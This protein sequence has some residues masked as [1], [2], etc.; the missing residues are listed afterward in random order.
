MQTIVDGKLI[1]YIR[2][3]SGPVVLILHGWADRADNW[4]QF[5]AKMSNDFDVVVPS[6]PGFGGSESPSKA[7]GLEDYAEF[8]KLF[9]S[10]LGIKPEVII[11]HSNG[12]AI[13][14]KGLADGIIDTNRLVLLASAGIRSTDSRRKSILKYVAKTG[15]VITLVL[16]SSVRRKLRGKLYK[17]IGSDMLVSEH[18]QPTF[19][20]IVSQDV[21]ADAAQLQIPTL[22][23]YGENDDATPVSYGR[24]FHEQISSSSL[25]IIGGAGHFIYLDR[26][27]EVVSSIKAFIAND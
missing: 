7:W 20:K 9:T 24:L 2:Q 1:N 6:L 5:V 12:G 16:P 23:V 27:D 8:T 4:Q 18:M 10:K 14:I 25:E 17:T 19:K 21:M 26:P 13:A 15:K 3:G 22:L 11:G